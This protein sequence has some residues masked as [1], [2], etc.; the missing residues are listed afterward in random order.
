MKRYVMAAV[1]A[2]TAAAGLAGCSSVGSLAEASAFSKLGGSSGVT[3]LASNLVNS[4]ISDPRLASLTAGK[5]VDAAASSDKVSNQ[6]CAMLGGGCK[7]PLTESQI[8]SAASKLSPAQSQAI[9]DHFSTSL[10]SVASNSDVRDAVTKAVGSKL[11]GV[12]SGLL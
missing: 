1:I 9:T 2:A 5:S 4:S 12:V 3:S 11:P 7:A 6:L 10:A 8:E